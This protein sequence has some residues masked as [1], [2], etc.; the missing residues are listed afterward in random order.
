MRKLVHLFQRLTERNPVLQ[1]GREADGGQLLL[2]VELRRNR[3]FLQR[4]NDRHRHDLAV[5]RFQEDVFKIG[6]I[7]DR[8]GGGQEPHRDCIAIHE[9][10]NDRASFQQRLHRAR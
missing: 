10:V 1:I 4:S 3:I 8:P 2:A 6:R 7:I 9:N 5:A